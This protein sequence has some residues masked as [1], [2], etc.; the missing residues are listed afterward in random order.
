MAT[1]ALRKNRKKTSTDKQGFT[2]IELLLAVFIFSLVMI[3]AV[4]LFV[5]FVTFQ[6]RATGIQQNME[7]AR[8]AME[9][10]AKT[11][12]TSSVVSCAGAATCPPTAESIELYDYSQNKC[13]RYYKQDNKIWSGSISNDRAECDSITAYGITGTSIVNNYI[14]NLTFRAIKTDAAAFQVGKVTM[15]VEV[16]STDFCSGAENDRATL[17]TTVSLRDY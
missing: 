1:I 2:L 9:L 3:T 8:Y 12:R 4:F 16:C 13:V 10:M 17:Q 5:R 7:N 6:K 14:D 15:S 11:I